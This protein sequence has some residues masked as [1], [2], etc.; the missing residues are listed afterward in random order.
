MVQA[1]SPR[2]LTAWSKF[3]PRLV[4]VVFVVGEVALVPVFLRALY[5][6]SVPLHQCCLIISSSSKSSLNATKVVDSVISV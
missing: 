3:F 1:L 2:L 5:P 4:R 6:L